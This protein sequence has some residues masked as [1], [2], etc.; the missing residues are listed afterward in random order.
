MVLHSLLVGPAIHRHHTRSFHSHSRNRRDCIDLLFGSLQEKVGDLCIGDLLVLCIE[1][2][3]DVDG[4]LCMGGLGV[5]EVGSSR[6]CFGV[7]VVVVE[8]IVVVGCDLKSYC[9]VRLLW[10]VR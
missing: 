7:G 2:K 5:V 9:A 3:I 10:R 4:H 1:G 8:C 6:C